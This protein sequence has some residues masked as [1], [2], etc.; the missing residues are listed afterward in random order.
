MVSQDSQKNVRGIPSRHDRAIRSVV[1][2]G[3]W[4]YVETP[5]VKNAKVGSSYEGGTPR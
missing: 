3:I 5:L 1:H 4:R 2:L